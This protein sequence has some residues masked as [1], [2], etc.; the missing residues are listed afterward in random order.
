MVVLSIQLL[1]KN[2]WDSLNDV[3]G[4]LV[5]AE[6]FIF[7]LLNVTSAA[8]RNPFESNLGFLFYFR[9]EFSLF[10]FLSHDYMSF[11]R[12]LTDLISQSA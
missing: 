7:S 12:L 5:F 6:N 11:T 2:Q 3:E 10:C 4:K 9:F 1:S 8:K